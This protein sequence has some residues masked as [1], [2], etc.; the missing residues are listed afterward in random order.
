MNSSPRIKICG[1][2][3]KGDALAAAEYGADAIGLVFYSGSRRCVSIETAREIAQ[4]VGPFVTL[5]GLFVNAN[6]QAVRDVLQQV[7]L[8]VLQFHGN[9]TPAYCESFDRPYIK[10]LKV[11]PVSGESTNTESGDTESSIA[12]SRDAVAREAAAFASAQ[13]ILLDTLSNKGE[14]GTGE[15]FNWRC[16]PHDS[17]INWILAGGLDADN[18]RQAIHITLPYGVD[19]SSG[20]ELSPGIKDPEKVRLFIEAVRTANQINCGKQT[21]MASKA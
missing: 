14:G 1:I 17:D 7:P 12:A 21:T 3:A 18:A 16:V 9:E 5:V 13:G 20:V 6:E 19:V 4:V 11:K 8:H 2:T 15:S 10:A